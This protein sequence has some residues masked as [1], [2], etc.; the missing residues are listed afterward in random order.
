[1]LLSVEHWLS[2]YKAL[3]SIPTT[4]K[5]KKNYLLNSYLQRIQYQEKRQAPCL[6]CIFHSSSGME[7]N[8]Q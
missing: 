6:P 8:T 7:N 5:T 3:G 1:M 2:M 4:A